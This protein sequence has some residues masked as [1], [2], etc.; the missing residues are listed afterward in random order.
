MAGEIQ[1]K[2]SVFDH[3]ERQV[4]ELMDHVLR[5]RFTPVAYQRTWAPRVDVYE[6]ADEYIAVVELAGVDR[7]NVT[8][9]VEEHELAI[10][11]ERPIPVGDLPE[12]G[13]GC[14][15]LEIPYGPFE[16]RLAFPVALD[17]ARA[18]ATFHDGMLS[19]RVPKAP[20]GPKRVQ[21][22]VQ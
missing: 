5:W 12:T 3:L 20:R 15:Q 19:V 10:V 21:V 11:G 4:E 17:P 1:R 7:D 18:S 13:A 22:D 9:E 6:T 8:I 16:R 14:L 2:G